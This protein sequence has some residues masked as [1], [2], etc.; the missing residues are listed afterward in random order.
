MK[1]AITIHLQH[2]HVAL[3]QS[4]KHTR[5][6]TVSAV[7]RLRKS[8][9][10]LDPVLNVDSDATVEAR[11]ANISLAIRLNVGYSAELICHR[12]RILNYSLRRIGTFDK[13]VSSSMEASFVDWAL[14]VTCWS[15]LVK[16]S[17][18]F[19][20]ISTSPSCDMGSELLSFNLRYSLNRPC[21]KF[22]YFSNHSY[23]IIPKF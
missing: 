16:G 22:F 18:S 11:T 13:Y 21:S 7:I 20:A 12:A 6:S 1:L 2:I 4:C 19:T 15:Q 9:S 8:D 5:A 14:S 10:T 3:I 17:W 23:G